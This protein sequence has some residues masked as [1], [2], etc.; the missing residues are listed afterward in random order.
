MDE[1][2][3]NEAK[4]DE[5]DKIDNEAHEDEN[6]FQVGE[7]E[8]SEMFSW[9]TNSILTYLTWGTNLILT[10]LTGNRR[11]KRIEQGKNDVSR[12]RVN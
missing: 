1:T 7:K 6:R 11:E 4:D 8:N 9:G 5:R 2:G 12:S 10:Y 3:N